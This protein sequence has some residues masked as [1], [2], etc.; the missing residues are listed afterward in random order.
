M[1]RKLIQLASMFILALCIWGHVSEIFDRWDN[2]FQTGNDVEYNTVIV[3]LTV[4]AVIGLA[5]VAVLVLSPCSPAF[6]SLPLLV[7]HPPA[8]PTPTGFT[9]Y[10]P[11]PPLRI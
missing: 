5:R 10:S 9:G 3:V 8:S 4:G 6:D 1:Q 7:A 11:P 2:T